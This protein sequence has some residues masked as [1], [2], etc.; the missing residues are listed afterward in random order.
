[1][2]GFKTEQEGFWAGEFGAQYINRNPSDREMGARLALF[3][4]IMSRTREVGSIIELGPNPT[5]T[6]V[7]P[8]SMYTS[9]SQTRG[10][11]L[12]LEP[13]R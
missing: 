3:A 9:S 5:P 11:R 10:A 4:R 6:G 13:L 8:T 7:P 1:M 2:S 12:P